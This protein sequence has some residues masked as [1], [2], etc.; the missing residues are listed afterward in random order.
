MRLAT[1]LL[2]SLLF[3]CGSNQPAAN[4]EPGGGGNDAG[5]GTGNAASASGASG[6]G[7][8]SDRDDEPDAGASAQGD[9]GGGAGEDGEAGSSSNAGSGPCSAS[10]LIA[11]NSAPEVHG[12]A[13]DRVALFQAVKVPL[14]EQMI[15]V[16]DRRAQA[17]S[18][19]AGMLRVY[20]TPGATWQARSV[21]ARLTLVA[22]GGMT[23]TL[24]QTQI[25]S[26]ESS[27]AALSST[28][29]FELPADAMTEDL[30]YSVELFE[31]S[32]CFANQETPDNA[33][34]PAQGTQP[35]GLHMGSKLR[36]EL[37]PV[38]F[39]VGQPAL[40][41]DT[42]VDQLALLRRK[43]MA[44]FPITGIDLT[45]HDS[46]HTLATDL[47]GVLSEIDALRA[48]ENAPKNLS[49]FG[50]VRFTDNIDQYCNPSCV[51]G[52]SYTGVTPEGG[53]G[54]GIGYTGDKAALTFAHELGHVYGRSHTPCG[55]AGDPAYPYSAGRIGSWGYDVASKTLYDPNAYTDFMGYCSPT[56][57]SD[58]TYENLRVFIA[59][60]A[61]SAAMSTIRMSAALPARA[62]SPRLNV[63]VGEPSSL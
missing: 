61:P 45:V 27:D 47:V 4:G 13:L 30:Q 50:L 17:V 8:T 41:P 15:E 49:Y 24:D 58:Y 3:A 29:N 10:D 5:G 40:L 9:L 22:T 52:A 12:L 34:F 21:R 32:G 48:A 14:M 2:F 60:I 44:L 1:P 37:V 20:V 46:V 31:T 57:V 62:S 63:Y 33:R 36:V 23:Q 11:L 53:T 7:G 51:L 38:E 28:F 39:D 25:V 43:V 16:T 35:I 55:V 54:V 59:A 56:W 42:S 18:G 19:R 6:E 26:T